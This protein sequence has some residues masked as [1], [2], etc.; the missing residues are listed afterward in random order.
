MARQ[1]QAGRGERGG[2]GRGGC[3]GRFPKQNEPGSIPRKSDEVGACEDLE[4]NVFNIGSGNKGKDGDMLRTSKEKLALYIG[5]NFGD[6]ACKEWL[7][8]KQLVL[9]EPTY[10]DSVLAR[11]AVRE[12]A[13]IDRVTKMVTSLGKQLQ[14]IE[15]ELLLTSK[16]LSLLK[17][18]MEV[19]NKREISKFELTDVVEV[20]T[21]A[22]EGM[23]FSNSWRT[24]RERTD[25][26]VRSQGKV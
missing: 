24:Y 19:E 2:G 16:D 9:Q 14:V 4:E 20:K 12:K 23:A 18:Q 3:G 26:L 1:P 15:S 10:P 21:N 8:E 5:T 7:S 11:H 13:V 17:S 6:D 22:D 25:R